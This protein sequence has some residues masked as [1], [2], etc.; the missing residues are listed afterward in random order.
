MQKINSLSWIVLAGTIS[1]TFLIW[2]GYSY[3]LSQSENQRFQNDADF[4]TQLI[5]DEL[6][7]YEQILIG[8]RAFLLQQ[9]K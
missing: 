3:S 8:Q 2:G 9:I 5:R 7:H 4:I 1:I 6:E